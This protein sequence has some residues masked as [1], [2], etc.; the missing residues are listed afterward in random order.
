MGKPAMT[1]AIELTE[2]AERARVAGDT[3]AS[4]VLAVKAAEYL[5]LAKLLAD[6]APKPRP[7]PKLSPRCTQ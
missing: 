1:I 7:A 2:A 3:V 5:Q 4:I 6:N